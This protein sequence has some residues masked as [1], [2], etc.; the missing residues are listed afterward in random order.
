MSISENLE[1]ES[2]IAATTFAATDQ[3]KWVVLDDE[4]H[5]IL[6]NTTGNVLPYGILYGVTQTTSTEAESVPVAVGGV[7]KLRMAASTLSVGDYVGSS[8]AGLGIAPSTDAYTAGVIKYGS[9]GSANR[10]VSVKLF[11]GPLSSP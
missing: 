7:A 5:A 9:S 11:S 2:V 10:I 8:T 4:G 1:L 3:F 6:P